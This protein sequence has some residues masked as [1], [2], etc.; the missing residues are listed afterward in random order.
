MKQLILSLCTLLLAWPAVAEK[1]DPSRFEREVLVG[2]SR[3]AIQFE[4]LANGDIVFVEFAGGVKRWSAKTR[5]VTTLGQV[6]TYAKGEVG[7]LGFAVSPNYL[8]NGHLFTLHCPT[9]KQDTMRVSRFVVKGD[10][11]DVKGEEVLLEWPYDDDHIYHMGGAVFMD[12]LL[13]TS[14]SPRDS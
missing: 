4:V 3:D 1:Y 12:C 2:S 13:Y 8:K 14:P 6:P 9:A 7:L 10:V 11:M 5:E